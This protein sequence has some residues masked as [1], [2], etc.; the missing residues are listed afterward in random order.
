VAGR[1]P[2]PEPDRRRRNA[3]ARGEV[4]T[5]AGSGWQHRTYPKPPA[6]LLSASRIAWS[7]WFAA[8]FAAHWTKADLPG[9]RIVIMLHD[10]VERGEYQRAG[11]LRL[12]LDT[13][14]V[15]PKGQQDRRWLKPEPKGTNTAADRYAAYG[16]LRSVDMSDDGSHP[17]HT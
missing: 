17:P 10:Q 12:W 2:A 4:T 7:T 16:H 11:E 1:G 5:A 14:G 6:G 15:T 3:P 8:W 13:Y 9:L